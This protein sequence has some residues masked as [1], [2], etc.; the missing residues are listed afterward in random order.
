M[1]L[2]LGSSSKTYVLSL[3]ILFKSSGSISIKVEVDDTKAY[4]IVYDTSE[5]VMEVEKATA[6]YGIGPTREWRKITRN[7]STDFNK[8]FG[9]RGRKKQKKEKPK[10]HITELQSLSFR[11]TG[12]IGKEIKSGSFTCAFFIVFSK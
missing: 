7:L 4:T 8:A 3:D 10:L 2:Q 9:E 11:G 12:Y 6:T 1:T 5:T